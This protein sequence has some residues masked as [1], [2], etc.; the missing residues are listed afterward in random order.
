MKAM[1]NAPNKQVKDGG[2]RYYGQTRI[3]PIKL[4]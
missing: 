2:A 1:I 4:R 3:V